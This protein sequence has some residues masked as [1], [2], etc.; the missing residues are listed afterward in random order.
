MAEGDRGGDKQLGNQVA[1]ESDADGKQAFQVF[2]LQTTSFVTILKVK[3]R[4]EH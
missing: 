3:S 1:V 2:S 4:C